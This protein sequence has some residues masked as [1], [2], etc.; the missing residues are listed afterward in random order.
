MRH[1]MTWQ[2]EIDELHRRKELA[3]QMGGPERVQRQHDNGRLTVRERIDRL[4]D[5]GT[6][7]ETGEL[8]GFGTYDELFESAAVL[9]TKLGKLSAPPHPEDTRELGPLKYVSEARGP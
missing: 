4:F 3:H 8:A 7:H 6:F 2:P 1:L 9:F 5:D